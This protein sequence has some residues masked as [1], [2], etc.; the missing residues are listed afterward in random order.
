MRIICLAIAGSILLYTASNA[1][2]DVTIS[3]ASTQ[4]VSCS[5]GVCAP[6][7][8]DA[9][10]NVGDLESLLASGNVEI[11]TT[12]SGTQADNI[13]IAAALSWSSASVLSLD[14]YQ[15]IVVDRPVMITG[16]SG[17]SIATN[18]GERDPEKTRRRLCARRRL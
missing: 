16:L 6:T 3:S 17:L 5:G 8:T 15:S 7:A 9:V 14:A 10:L 18:D 2:A 4:N 11:T 12:G 1:E 13:D